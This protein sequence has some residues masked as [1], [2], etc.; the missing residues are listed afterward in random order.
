MS[1]GQDFRVC[2]PG[3]QVCV[4]RLKGLTEEVKVRE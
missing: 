3:S 2:L 1:E 4:G